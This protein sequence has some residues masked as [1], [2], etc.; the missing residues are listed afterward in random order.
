[1]LKEVL[2]DNFVLFTWTSFTLSEYF[3]EENRK[4]A[5]S[6]KR[7]AQQTSNGVSYLEYTPKYLV[8]FLLK[9]WTTFCVLQIMTT[10]KRLWKYINILSS[11]VF[12]CYKVAAD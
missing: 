9:Y 2:K 4:R 8:P 7:I 5:T 11:F 10:F 6:E 12:M 1:M 3:T